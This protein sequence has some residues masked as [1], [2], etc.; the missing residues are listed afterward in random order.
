MRRM[1]PRM[2][3]LALL[4]MAAA[5]PVDAQHYLS[6]ELDS[7]TIRSSAART[8]SDLLAG[9]IPGLG[10][11]Q[12]SGAPG[13]APQV[14]ARGALAIVGA[15]EPLLYVDGILVRDDPY[16]LGSKPD[17]HRPS[18]AWDLPVDEIESVKVVLGQAQGAL[19]EFG[20]ARGAVLVR[21]RRPA[22]GETR[23]RGFVEGSATRET[24]RYADNVGVGGSTTY[25]QYPYECTLSEQALG[26]CVA[27]G[28]VRRN[29]LEPASPFRVGRGTRAGV[30][31]TGDAPLGVYR[32]SATFDRDEAV[33]GPARGERLDV[34]ASWSTAPESRLAVSADAR[35]ANSHARF[36][37]WENGVLAPALLSPHTDDSSRVYV[38]RAFL[39]AQ[40]IHANRTTL[41]ASVRW[42]FTARLNAHARAGVDRLV[43]GSRQFS[44]VPDVVGGGDPSTQEA[45]SGARMD[46]WSF[47]AGVGFRHTL[48]GQR[49]SFQATMFRSHSELRDSAS[50]ESRRGS[51][52]A[53]SSSSLRSRL[54]STGLSLS[55]RV[56]AGAAGQRSLTVGMRST[57]LAFGEVGIGGGL[58]HSVEASWDLAGESFFPHSAVRLMRL[59]AAHGQ[60]TDVEAILGLAPYAFSSGTVD[61]KA[62]PPRVAESELGLDAAFLDGA[63]T[64]DARAFKRRATNVIVPLPRG[65]GVYTIHD[66]N[67]VEVKGEEL[68]VAINGRTVGPLRLNASG[69]ISTAR[70]RVVKL[71]VPAF[72]A[73]DPHNRSRIII[74]EGGSLGDL[75]VGSLSW[76]DVNGDGI[77]DE[78]EIAVTPRA[79]RGRSRPNRLLA[80][81]LDVNWRALTAGA[82]LDAQGGQRAYDTTHEIRCMLAYCAELYDPSTPLAEQARAVAARTI[83]PAAGALQDGSFTRLRE[84]W[85]RVALPRRLVPTA[86]G[87]ASITLAG[88]QLATWTSF[89]GPDPEIGVFGGGSLQ[90]EAWFG[91]P[92]LPT[93][94]LRLD[95]GR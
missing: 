26:R 10:V 59:R 25:P 79:E 20:A 18:F 81:S 70:D 6:F 94:S 56:S 12:A 41:G 27:S 74:E 22:H 3:V 23:V 86:V 92:V 83:A 84:I 68:L 69:S 5:P 21:T 67:I 75:I 63:L 29:P 55:E 11:T 2:L 37:D 45:L 28:E 15:V 82:V 1:M 61:L 71:Y 17:G 14:R 38:E 76:E 36:V 89:D 24:T 80:L 40:P 58:A 48:L 4:A 72:L 30:S 64:V 13:L 95:L 31:A 47:E 33:M 9:R 54:R 60:A 43:R 7:A 53:A 93:W 51:L 8:L 73:T 65:E 57:D 35:H 87:S 78:T 66:R 39:N 88:R 85:V 62:H 19:M 46:A 77:I 50:V 91:Q 32:G 34:S 16:W 42:P 90:R 52:L 49:A 44:S